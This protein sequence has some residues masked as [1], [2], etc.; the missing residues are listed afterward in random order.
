M[1]DTNKTAGIGIAQVIGQATIAVICLGA[2]GPLD[3]FVTQA[4][5]QGDLKLCGQ[6]LNRA[7]VIMCLVAFPLI[8]LVN[9]FAWPLCYIF[10]RDE[11]VIQYAIEMLRVQTFVIFFD[12]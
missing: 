8:A 12:T 7:R 2:A 10:T 9:I 6:Y 1:G 3:T 5:G 11:V 4:Y